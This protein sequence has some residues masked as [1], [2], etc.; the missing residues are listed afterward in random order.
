MKKEKKPTTKEDVEKFISQLESEASACEDIG[1]NFSA[2]FMRLILKKYILSEVA[3]W[4]VAQSP[5]HRPDNLEIVLDKLNEG[6][7]KWSNDNMGYEKFTYKRLMD[8]LSR[9]LKRIPEFLLWNERKNG[10]QSQYKFI[11]RYSKDDNPDDDFID[12]DALIRNVA[13]SIIREGTEVSIQEILGKEKL[14]SE[15]ISNKK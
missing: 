4:A 1:S 13:N 15:D 9:E 11:D 7:G 8:F 6:L 10:N 12:L 3:K 14:T 5:Y 2:S